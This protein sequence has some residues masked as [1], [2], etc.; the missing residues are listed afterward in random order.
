MGLNEFVREP[1][2]THGPCPRLS[3]YSQYKNTDL[4][5]K[6]WKA[7][8]IVIPPSKKRGNEELGKYS[9]I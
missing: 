4:S 3:I 8:G 7:Q 5:K 6:R 2:K 9:L 1:K